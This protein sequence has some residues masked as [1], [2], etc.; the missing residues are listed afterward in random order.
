MGE[1]DLDDQYPEPY[2]FQVDFFLSLLENIILQ[3]Y[4]VTMEHVL[5]QEVYIP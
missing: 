5:N 3:I 1:Y 4:G 2:A